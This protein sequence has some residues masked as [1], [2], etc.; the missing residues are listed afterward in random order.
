[1]TV[2][3]SD[4]DVII[5]GKDAGHAATVNAAT[6]DQ[7]KLENQLAKTGE[8]ADKSSQQMDGMGKGAADSSAK[9]NRALLKFAESV[10][11]LNEHEAVAIQRQ[12]MLN[13][14]VVAGEISER[15][16]A[17][18]TQHTIDTLAKK[19]GMST[20]EAAKTVGLDDSQ[21]AAIGQRETAAKQAKDD[22]A[23]VQRLKDVTARAMQGSQTEFQ[24]YRAQLS[25]LRAAI[26][27]GV[28]DEKKL[29]P[30]I[31]A[32]K[33]KIRESTNAYKQ[34]TQAEKESQAATERLRAV[35]ERAIAGAQTDFQKYRAELK[36]LRTA[37][38]DGVKT[39]AEMAPAIEAVKQKIREST[40]AYKA[41]IREE[42]EL[43]AFS[44][45]VTASLKTDADKRAEYV[46]NLQRAHKKGILDA[47]EYD[48]A[49]AKSSKTDYT[50]A[51]K[52]L[53]GAATATAAAY[54]AVIAK[55]K[56]F[57]RQSASDIKESS[58]SI[59]ELASLVTTP[60]EH[61]KVKGM[62]TEI[63][64][65]GAT[66]AEG[67][68]GETQAMQTAFAINSA[69]LDRQLATFIEIGQSQLFPSDKMPELIK[70]IGQI[71]T[72]TE[73][74][75]G[76][77]RKLLSKGLIAAGPSP[78]NVPAILDATAEAMSKLE[79]SAT[80]LEDAMASIT[81]VGKVS[82]IQQAA[83]QAKAFVTSIVDASKEFEEAGIT[84][85]GVKGMTLPEIMKKIEASGMTDKELVKGFGR[86]EAFE[87]YSILKKD[88]NTAA[89]Q[90]LRQEIVAGGEQNA[91]GQRTSIALND[92]EVRA[93]LASRMASARE[94]M[95]LK[96]S[97]I[98][99]LA[100]TS[101]EKEI[102]AGVREKR[103]DFAGAAAATTMDF[104]RQG[105]AATGIPG[106]GIIPGMGNEAAAFLMPSGGLSEEAKGGL[107]GERRKAMGD[108]GVGELTKMEPS[109]PMQMAMK[110]QEAI[111]S[112]F[113]SGMWDMMTPQG[114]PGQFGR[115][116]SLM[117]RA[118]GTGEW[119]PEAMAAENRFAKPAAQ[120]D[121]TSRDMLQEM[122]QQ[123]SLLQKVAEGV[124]ARGKPRMPVIVG[125][126]QHQ[127]LAE[128]YADN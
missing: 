54:G 22:A 79:L 68:A 31:E 50:M 47:K 122:K 77:V 16:M 2:A 6:R 100:V 38:R 35:S 121:K 63:F 74:E 34:R 32:T 25:E 18:A 7:A 12:G 8:A 15:A 123:T 51:L 9:A 37:V 86:Q 69:K 56:E 26:R 49:L 90:T 104:L 114:L 102:S 87:Y 44:Q 99:E 30:A 93:S 29:A 115:G 52:G 1:L 81:I 65:K 113:I 111:G 95:S 92:R 61:A 45:R 127:Q 19:T 78:E 109:S 73:D 112:K 3:Q 46:R 66:K 28:A 120:E 85:A 108:F 103:G 23:Q 117:R 98:R 11:A 124:N 128:A 110:T 119:S 70:S 94:V 4:L 14:L 125:G 82:G 71:Q 106:G 24:K 39:Q 89:S 53:A 76:D 36:T 41:R 67:G 10:K 75:G 107:F 60:E 91:L 84:Q 42:Q 13:K 33:Q 43:A 96:E 40:P 97:G 126:D 21:V 62:G 57:A 55:Q 48:A 20:V 59:A 118:R 80:S 83:T 105:G 5:S 72:A 116:A 64:R 101:A 58:A 27:D 88:A 17:R